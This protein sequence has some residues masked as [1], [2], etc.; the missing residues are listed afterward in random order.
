MILTTEEGNSEDRQELF[1]ECA[2][3]RKPPESHEGQRTEEVG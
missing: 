2:L 1:V 3:I